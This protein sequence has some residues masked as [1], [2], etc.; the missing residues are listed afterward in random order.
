M[1]GGPSRNLV[2]LAAAVLIAAVL[3]AC[4]SDEPAATGAATSDGATTEETVAAA[5]PIR[6]GVKTGPLRVT[7]GGPEQFRDI[8]DYTTLQFGQESSRVA[9]EDAARV[10]HE[11]LVAH[12]K[13]DW[14]TSCA[15]LDDH[16]SKEVPIVGAHF[17]EVA[18]K[19]CP[20]IIAY[21]LGKVPARKTFVASEVDAGVLRVR[22]EGGYLFYRSGGVP[23]TI[24]LSRDEDGN[25]KLASFLIAKIEPQPS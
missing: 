16:A 14:A 20:T 19:D 4:G 9:L 7:Q 13:Y 15:L 11:F 5:A 6:S 24:N 8:G 12:V 25:W 21:L 23:Y 18:G 17:K 2:T 1:A 10:V 22:R 3:A